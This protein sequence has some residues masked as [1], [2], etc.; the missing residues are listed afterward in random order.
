MTIRYEPLLLSVR[1]RH[2][3]LFLV[4]FTYLLLQSML[5]SHIDIIIASTNPDII[6]GK[7]QHIFVIQ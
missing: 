4:V 6:L 1:Y 7:I 3:I 2:F 5:R